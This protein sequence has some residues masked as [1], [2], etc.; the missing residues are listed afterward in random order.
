M[1]KNKAIH[2]MIIG[3][4]VFVS[5]MAGVYADTTVTDAPLSIQIEQVS[6]SDPLMQKQN[7]ID[8]FVFETNAKD[9]IKK[10]ITVTNTGVIGDYVEVGIAP[11]NT[12]NANYIYEIFGKDQVKVVEGIQAT[13]LELA[14]SSQDVTVQLESYPPEIAEAQVV[15][16][17]I[18]NESSPV[19]SFFNNIWEWI[20]NIF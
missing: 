1:I 13:T 8:Q 4:C 20:K 2:A 18:D 9:F 5:S 3:T 7:E 12:E 6:A 10:G 19:A 17:T 14:D 15:S 16:A 11:F